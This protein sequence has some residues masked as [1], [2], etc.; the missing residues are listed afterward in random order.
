MLRLMGIAPYDERFVS[1]RVLGEDGVDE[2]DGHRG[3]G[4]ML[5]EEAW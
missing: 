3:S 2:V 5:H 4:P 1:E